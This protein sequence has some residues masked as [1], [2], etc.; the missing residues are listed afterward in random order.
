MSNPLRVAVDRIACDGRGLCAE[1]APGLIDLDDWGYPIVRPGAL[2]DE[3]VQSAEDAVEI[4]PKM[5]LR[6]ERLTRRR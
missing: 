4:C 6:L 1:I 3:L 2:P 5:A